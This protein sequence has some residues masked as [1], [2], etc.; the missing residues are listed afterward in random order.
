M[1]EGA[2]N[3]VSEGNKK[4][5][6]RYIESVK[7]DARVASQ[8]TID[9]NAKIMSFL[10]KNIKTDLDKLTIDDIDDIQSAITN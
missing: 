8:K 9:Y 2:Y 1:S 4:I 7:N 6:H 10:L 5:A 3:D